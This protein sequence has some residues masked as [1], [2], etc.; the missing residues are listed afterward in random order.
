MPPERREDLDPYWQDVLAD[1]EDRLDVALRRLERARR[2]A[3]TQRRRKNLEQ[4]RNSVL[5]TELARL[6]A[7]LA[8][9]ASS[10]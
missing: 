6:Q 2:R 9:T 4:A 10:T 7:A 1:L 8:S 3:L 5:R